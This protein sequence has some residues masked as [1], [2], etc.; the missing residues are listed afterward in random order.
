MRGTILRV[1]Q[2]E[3]GRI[4][5]RSDI[6]DNLSDEERDELVAAVRLA[7]CTGLWGKLETAVN[8]AIR[9]LAFGVVLCSSD[10]NAAMLDFRSETDRLLTVP[11]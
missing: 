10:M 9:Q 4:C 11:R 8:A 2:Y 5:L 1:Y 6:P 7:M 3:S